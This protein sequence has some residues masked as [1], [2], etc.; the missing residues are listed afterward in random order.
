MWDDPKMLLS[1]VER[2]LEVT[3]EIGILSRD[4]FVQLFRRPFGLGLLVDELYSLGVASLSITNITLLF[5]G[6]VIAIQTSYT[7]AAYGAKIYTGNMVGLSIALELGPVLTALMVAGRVGAG[8]TADIGTMQVTE[9]VDALRALAA[10]PVKRLVVPRLLALLIMVPALTLLATVVGIFGG[11]L[12]AV[13]DIGQTS[14]F[15]IAHVK[16]QLTIADLF[17]GLGKTPF[18]AFAIGIIACYNG[19]HT[20]GGADGVGRSTWNTV[21]AASMTI[22]V[23]NFFLAKLFLWL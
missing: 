9:Q 11:L 14:E 16:N 10:N 4:F 8:I 13:F 23:S 21:V 6:M 15:Y 18:F 5:T 12:M 22:F 17:R 19:L 2:P 7:L 3:G 20:T 1:L